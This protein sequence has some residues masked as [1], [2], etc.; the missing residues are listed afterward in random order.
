MGDF[1]RLEVWRVAH[2]LTCDIYRMT[3]DFPKDEQFGLTTQL[4]RAAVSI[5]A[6]IAEGCG[7]NTDGDLARYLA[8]A[9]GSANELLYLLLLSIDLDLLKDRSFVDRANRLCRMLCGLQAAARRARNTKRR[10]PIANSQLAIANPM[11]LGS[12]TL[13]AACESR[14]GESSGTASWT[15]CRGSSRRCPDASWFA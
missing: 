4:R 14:T 12:L 7:R 15:K 2:G 5:G 10:S 11:P 1:R 8:I 3:R 13:G 6:N 9:L